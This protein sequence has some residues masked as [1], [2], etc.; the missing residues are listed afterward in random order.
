MGK[1]AEEGRKQYVVV[2]GALLVFS[3]QDSCSQVRSLQW[4]WCVYIEVPELHV[5]YIRKCS[6]SAREYPSLSCKI[7]PHP[8][9]SLVSLAL[10]T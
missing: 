3:L 1:K 5:Q 9:L 4:A 6:S 8:F 7:Q 2:G 10:H